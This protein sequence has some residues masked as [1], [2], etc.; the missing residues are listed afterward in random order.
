MAEVGF[1]GQERKQFGISVSAEVAR[2]HAVACLFGNPL[3][4]YE[5]K[6]NLEAYRREF[7]MDEA[8]ALPQTY[9]FIRGELYSQPKDH[10]LFNIKN[11]IDDRERGGATLVGFKKYETQIAN[12]PLDSVGVWYSPDGAS[13]FEGIH[14]DAG[15]L[16]FSFKTAENQSTHFDI[17]VR[18]EFPIL[19]LLGD[20]QE[21]TNGTHPRFDSPEVGKMYYLTH[22]IQ[23]SMGVNEFFAYMKQYADKENNL[24]YI[25]RRNSKNPEI[26]TLSSTMCEMKKMLEKQGEKRTQIFEPVGDKTTTAMMKEDDLMR[27]YLAVIQPYVEKNNGT[28]TL[29]GC[30]TTSTVSSEDIQGLI[31]QNSL[32]NVVSLHSTQRRLLTNENKN[33]LSREIQNNSFPC[34]KCHQ[35]IPSGEGKTSCPH[36]GITK[37][38][39]AEEVG[40][41]TCA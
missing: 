35:S 27:R 28:Y 40:R 11:Q 7:L 30:S 36:C 14:F 3:A 12:A 38:K 16:Y 33:P 34:P 39:Y 29:Y 2:Y 23:T 9:H 10:P 4:E 18:L 17:K 32:E 13:G 20:I 1:V 21:Q 5:G 31:A 6:R 24:I 25:S 41:S 26:R 15:R 19:S 22:P 37:E 8:V